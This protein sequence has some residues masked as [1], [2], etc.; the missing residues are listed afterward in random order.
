MSTVQ[1]V[2]QVFGWVFVLVGVLGFVAGSASMEE[3]MLLGLFPV[4]LLHNLVHLA[5]GIWGIAAARSFG[6][7]KTY[8][9]AGGVVYLLLAVVGLVAAN[10]L[11]L[12]PLGGNDIWLHALLGAI[13]A[14]F[15]FTAKEVAAAAPAA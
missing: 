11:D 9:Q 15:G 6:G 5:F 2:A 1:R 13:L 4:N 10:P 8:G 12:V 14:Y 3:G 7:A